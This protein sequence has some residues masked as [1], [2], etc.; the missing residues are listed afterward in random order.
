MSAKTITFRIE[1]EALSVAQENCIRWSLREWSKALKGKVLF[2]ED[3]DADWQFSVGENETY[4]RHIAQCYHTTD[5]IK[6]ITFDPRARWAVT[7]W[8]RLIGLGNCFRSIALHEIGH[9]L[10][11][12][13]SIDPSSIMFPKPTR[14]SIDKESIRL[15]SL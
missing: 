3:K 5:F 15:L 8:Q 4:P 13:H 1:D 11:L 14:T 10:G 7:G 2:R 6:S 12:R 9:A